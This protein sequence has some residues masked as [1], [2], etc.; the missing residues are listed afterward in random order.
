M[1][2]EDCIKSNER[3]AQRAIATQKRI[4][5]RAKQIREREELRKKWEGWKQGA[6]KEED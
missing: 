1:S 4:K 6:P 2:C 5:A 3:H